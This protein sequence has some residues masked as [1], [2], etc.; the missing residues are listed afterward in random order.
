MFTEE[1]L[2]E[3]IEQFSS[4]ADF[5]E[6]QRKM[7]ESGLSWSDLKGETR[8]AMSD[9]M[10]RFPTTPEEFRGKPHIHYEVARR[11]RENES[12]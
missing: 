4:P 1:E 2:L 7:K 6:I 3:A 12:V 5:N 11:K 10:K 9:A 8:K